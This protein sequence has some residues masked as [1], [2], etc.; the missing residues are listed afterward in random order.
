MHYL[1]R[2]FL[3][4][5]GLF[6]FLPQA[7]P[8][9]S[10]DFG[11]EIDSVFNVQ[12][13]DSSQ[14]IDTIPFSGYW[15]WQIADLETSSLQNPFFRFPDT[16]TFDVCLKIISLDS[17]CI[18]SI[19]KTIE[20]KRPPCN[21]KFSYQTENVYTVHFHDSSSEN[22]TYRRWDFG[23]WFYSEETNP[24]HK[25]QDKAKYVVRLDVANEDSTCMDT[26]NDTV[27]ILDT[28]SCHASFS[29]FQHDDTTFQFIQS[30]NG[31]FDSV[32]WDFGDGKTST[33]D[34]IIHIYKKPG[35]YQ[36]CLFVKNSLDTTYCNDTLCQIIV[37]EEYINLSGHV[38]A[39]N[40]YLERGKIYLYAVVEEK[41]YLS[42][43]TDVADGDFSLNI[44]KNG[45]YILKCI[46]GEEYELYPPTYYPE[47]L[48]AESAHVFNLDKNTGGIDLYLL[49]QNETTTIN[50]SA[51]NHTLHVF[52]NPARDKVSVDF[53]PNTVNIKLFNIQGLPILTQSL[54]GENNILLNL[55][56]I[57]PGIYFVRIQTSGM[58]ISEKLLVK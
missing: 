15:S 50:T 39:G 53:P 20:I 42:D 9:C 14:S 32:T 57:K 10:S 29:Y 3:L 49:E 35:N 31:S 28:A 33:G 40:N 51:Y 26:Y 18:D 58:V 37:L 56:N 46:P 36:V 11:Y 43:S 21:A 17:M 6:T 25:Y 8:Q 23:D 24:T 45:Q 22:I 47:A 7:Y 13:I 34:S 41:F 54:N 55:K 5:F 48:L 27:I 52:P 38:Y 2:I 4:C 12:F 16:G 1:K 30:S 19:C 44:K